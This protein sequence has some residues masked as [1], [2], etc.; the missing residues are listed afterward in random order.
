MRVLE[1]QRRNFSQSA[2]RI[3]LHAVEDFHQ[4]KKKRDSAGRAQDLSGS[5]VSTAQS[6]K[7]LHS[8]KSLYAWTSKE[9]ANKVRIVS[10]KAYL[11]DLEGENHETC[12]NRAGA[13]SCVY[14]RL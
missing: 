9:N 1:L 3:Y 5:D 10:T 4:D 13:G 14:F 7:A 8:D 11:T 2:T 12:L 6:Q